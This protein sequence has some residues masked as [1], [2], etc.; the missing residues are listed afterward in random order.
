MAQEPYCS[1]SFMRIL[2]TNAAAT[3]ETGR[4]LAAAREALVP[5]Q[6]LQ[7]DHDHDHSCDVS[8][9]SSTD[10]VLL[11]LQQ[12]NCRYYRLTSSS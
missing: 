5:R 9:L 2:R 4:T 7:I 6:A 8:I 12:T 3:K 11:R 1:I 10:S